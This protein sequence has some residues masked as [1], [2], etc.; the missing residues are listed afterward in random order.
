MSDE[1]ERAAKGTR[2][3][4]QEVQHTEESRAALK[5]LM[6]KWELNNASDVVRDAL[7]RSAFADGW[8]GLK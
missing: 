8:K 1:R 3:G 2:V 7:S 4:R 5:W 6:R